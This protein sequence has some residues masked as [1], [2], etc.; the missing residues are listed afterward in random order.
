MADKGRGAPT[1]GQFRQNPTLTAALLPES[2]M[3]SVAAATSP[4]AVKPPHLHAQ[5]LEFN[6]F[7]A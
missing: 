7:Y 3:A 6:N 1:L 4:G 2:I 5:Q